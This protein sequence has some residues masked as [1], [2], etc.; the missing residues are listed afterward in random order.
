MCQTLRLRH[1]WTKLSQ[2]RDLEALTNLGCLDIPLATNASDGIDLS[3]LEERRGVFGA[4]IHQRAPG[5]TYLQLVWQQLKDPM[6]ILL[7]AAATVRPW[8]AYSLS[9]PLT[10]NPNVPL[11]PWK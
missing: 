8:P 2:E 5:T 6:L 1:A 11:F 7:M 10:L 3:T 4:N 9:R